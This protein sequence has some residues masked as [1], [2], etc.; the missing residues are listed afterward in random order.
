VWGTVYRIPAA[1][2]AAVKE[3]L[4]IREINGYSIDYVD[5]HHPN[6]ECLPPIKALVYIGPF[7]TPPSPSGSRG[8]NEAAGTPENPQFVARDG[9]VPGESELAEHIFKSCGPSGENR[10]YLYQLHHALEDLCPESKDNHVRSLFR[11]VCILEAEARLTGFDDVDEEP[12]MASEDGN[13]KGDV[14]VVMN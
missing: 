1:H 8:A 9:K 13:G 7:H 6:D 14:D 5:V 11:K 10:D 4:D 12:T 3:Y 2:V